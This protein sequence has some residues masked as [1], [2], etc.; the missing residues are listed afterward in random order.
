MAGKTV[1]HCLAPGRNLSV[2][3]GRKKPVVP[4]GDLVVL[5]LVPYRVVCEHLVTQCR[6]KHFV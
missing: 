1:G 6:Y 2:G 4:L 3:P 5:G